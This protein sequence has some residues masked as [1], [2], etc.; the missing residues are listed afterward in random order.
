MVSITMAAGDSLNPLL[1]FGRSANQLC[2]A[3]GI[4][5]SKAWLTN[6]DEL[7]SSIDLR[8]AIALVAKFGDDYD[9]IF[10]GVAAK[11]IKVVI[12]PPRLVARATESL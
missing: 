12:G 5:F 4:P 2:Y 10:E 9:A 3:T 11:S 1:S 6:R 7:M 8:N